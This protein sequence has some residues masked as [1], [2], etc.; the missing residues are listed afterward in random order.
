MCPFHGSGEAIEVARVGVEQAE[1]NYRI[2]DEQFQESIAT[3]QEVLDTQT[4]RSRAE[5]YDYDA[6]NSYNIA[7]AR[8]RGSR[9][10]CRNGGRWRTCRPVSRSE[11]GSLSRKQTRGTGSREEE[12]GTEDSRGPYRIES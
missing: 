9:G 1:E 6:L 12:G 8:R 2:T 11:E 4:G 3:S 7:I 5:V 10:F